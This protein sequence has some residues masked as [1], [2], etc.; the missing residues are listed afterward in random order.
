MLYPDTILQNR[1]HIIAPLGQGGMGAVY[2]AIDQ[3]LSLTVALKE[4]LAVTDELRRAFEREARLLANLNHPSLPRVIDHFIEG[5][6]Q[7]L[8][9][10]YVPN[11][12][13]G[14][15]LSR[16]GTPFPVDEVVRWSQDL[17][18][19]LDYLHTHEPQIIHRD[20]KP[21]NIKVS[22][23]GKIILLDFGLAKGKAGEMTKAAHS[24]SILGYSLYYASLEQI[25]GDRTSERSD[26]YSLAVT[27]YNLLTGIKPPDALTRAAAVFNDEPDPLI[28]IQQLVPS[29]PS[30]VSETLMSAAALKPA[31]R[32]KSAKEMLLKLSGNYQSNPFTQNLQEREEET[33]VRSAPIFGK[34]EKPK[35]SN[36]WMYATVALVLVSAIGLG[37]YFLAN[38]S[39]QT[40]SNKNQIAQVSETQQSNHSANSEGVSALVNSN[41]DAQIPT[42]IPTPDKAQLQKILNSYVAKTIATL[43]REELQGTPIE[44]RADVF[45]YTLNGKHIVY[46]DLDKDGDQDAIVDFDFCESRSCHTTTHSSTLVVF[47]NNEGQFSFTS[48]VNLQSLYGVVKSIRDGKIYIELT[49]LKEDDPQCCPSDKSR[50]VYMLIGN[51][52]AKVKG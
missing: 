22:A 37:V 48:E 28:P 17:L 15:M 45:K 33:I 31:S 50:V 11:D 8:V 47:L 9:M 38:Q 4:T 29:L 34:S 7:Y 3:R 52:L 39:K 5:E 12:D 35:S 30:Q 20:I 6:G 19:V 16:K 46:N 44:D 26:L 2:K 18:E 51:K 42:P 13:L 27:L 25:Q 40:N 43:N 36:V 1:Y 32:P 24:Q 23:K 14:T 10:D 49:N 21:T 41:I